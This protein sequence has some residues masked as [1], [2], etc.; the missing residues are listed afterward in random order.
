MKKLMLIFPLFA[1]STLAMADDLTANITNTTPGNSTGAID[2]TVSGGVAPYT[3]SWTGPNG[4]L[5]TTEDLS[6]LPEGSY[7]VTVTD[8]YCGVATLTVKIASS[9]VGIAD[10]SA[11]NNISISP[12]P[13]SNLFTI[14]ADQQLNRAAIHVLA[15]NGEVIYQQE[16]VSGNDFKMDASTLSSGI[17][18]VEVICD[19]KTSR[20]K[21]LKN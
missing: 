6:N 9:A 21:L 1:L 18:F 16:N 15:I 7:T 2:L 10:N 4:N 8:K 17:Y 5:G 12:N 3:Y 13:T 11:A 20:I 14:H 19:N